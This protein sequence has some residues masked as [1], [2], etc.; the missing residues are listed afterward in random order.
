[1]PDQG[2]VAGTISSRMMVSLVVIVFSQ[3]AKA[4]LFS[5]PRR[6]SSVAVRHRSS[7]GIDGPSEADR[8]DVGR[9]VVRCGIEWVRAVRKSDEQ[10]HLGAEVD[11][12]AAGTPLLV[13]E[14]ASLAVDAHGREEAETGR[15]VALA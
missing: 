13:P 10:I 9:C 2:R 6:A 11:E 14:K 3:S 1:M 12:V 15:H 8:L 5:K 4:A 7:A